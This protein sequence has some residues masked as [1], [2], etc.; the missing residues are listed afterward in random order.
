MTVLG[1]LRP[2]FDA[3]SDPI[4]LAVCVSLIILELAVWFSPLSAT[5]KARSA[6]RIDTAPI[7]FPAFDSRIHV[8]PY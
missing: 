6:P 8:I 4:M 2:A 3:V 1:Q 5:A 7:A